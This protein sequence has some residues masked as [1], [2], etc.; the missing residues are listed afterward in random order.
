MAAST[1]ISYNVEDINNTVRRT[2]MLL[3]AANAIRLSI[4]DIQQSWKDPNLA[5]VMWT[6]VQLSRT[7]NALR[8]IHKLVTA[9][10]QMAGSLMGLMRRIVYVEPMAAPTVAPVFDL[11]GLTVRVDAFLENIPV[12]LPRIDLT[13]LPENTRTMLQALIEDDAQVTV[14]N[15]KELLHRRILH[16]EESTGNLEASI[17]WEPQVDGV[18][19]VADE[20]YAWWVERG[21]DSFTGHWY[22]TDAVALQ[23][24]R[25]P[26][27]IKYELNGLIFGE[28]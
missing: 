14:E 6:L 13:D 26:E 11:S 25:L 17:Y 8:R 9:E 21:H 27:R 15:A 24:V 22:M 19:L 7:Y 16:P 18:R 12:G 3:R 10:A 5:N 28:P 23:R 20:Y 1:S 4:R 2:N